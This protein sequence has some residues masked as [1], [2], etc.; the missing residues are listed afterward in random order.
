MANAFSASSLTFNSIGKDKN[1]ATKDGRMSGYDS[2]AN[3]Q[4]H[5]VHAHLTSAANPY[6]E[7]G[8]V[9]EAMRKEGASNETIAAFRNLATV[10]TLPLKVTGCDCVVC[11]GLVILHLHRSALF[12]APDA[13]LFEDLLSIFPCVKVREAKEARASDVKKEQ[14]KYARSER[15]QLAALSKVKEGK[16]PAGYCYVFVNSGGK[17]KAC[18]AVNC[19]FKH[20]MPAA[21]KKEFSMHQIAKKINPETSEEKEPIKEA[22]A[23]LRNPQKTLNPEAIIRGQMP[24]KPTPVLAGVGCVYVG[25]VIVSNGTVA[26]NFIH[27]PKHVIIDNFGKHEMAFVQGDKRQLILKQDIQVDD[28]FD[29]CQIVVKQSLNFCQLRF[30]KSVD[31]LVHL[32]R[33]TTDGK[34]EMITTQGN[35]VDVKHGLYDASSFMGDCGGAVVNTSGALV[36]IHIAGAPNGPNQFF[37]LVDYLKEKNFQ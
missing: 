3:Q 37:N 28:D 10:H 13:K 16:V 36:G 26:G 22:F 25:S 1:L 33:Y 24:F 32:V 20:E 12:K 15:R 18:K 29:Y 21:I 11:K 2:F 4:H 31:N 7:W 14:K 19:A 8:L 27:L 30:A 17:A 9:E 34:N 35:V 23:S 5:N 6:G